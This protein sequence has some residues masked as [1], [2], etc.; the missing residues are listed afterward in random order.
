MQL[1]S[2]DV[3]GGL[4]VDYDG[5]ASMNNSSINYKLD[6]YVADVVYGLKQACDTE[7]I[8]HPTIV[9]ESGRALTAHHSCVVTNIIGE[10]D[11]NKHLLD[12]LSPRDNEHIILKNIRVLE[13]DLS[14]K[15]NLQ[16]AYNDAL[17]Y[18]SD[19]ISAFKLGI[20]SLEDQAIVDSLYWKTLT[21]IKEIFEDSKKYTETYYELSELLASQYLCNMSVF[22]SAADSWAIDQIL[23]VVPLQRLNEEPKSNCSL[24]DITCDSDGKI[25]KFVDHEGSVNKNLK[26]HKLDEKNYYIGL[27]LTGAYQDVMGDMHNLFGRLN[28][29]HIYFHEDE[30]DNFYIE[31]TIHGSRAEDVLSTMQYNPQYMAFLIKDSIDQEISAKKIA[32]REGVKLID[33]YEN[34]L[35]EYT[36]LK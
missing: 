27:F 29:A 3:G 2:Q 7:N 32:P 1:L 34:C 28:E 9:T 8:A 26:L 19:A 5:T 11:N 17:K 33:F 35:K 18:K 30:A 36:Y 31:E 14:A 25:D 13:R 21:K 24:V 23:P 12:D 20:F 15:S 16:E 22:Q 10:I 6:E 4:G